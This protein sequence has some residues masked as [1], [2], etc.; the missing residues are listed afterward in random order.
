MAHADSMLDQCTDFDQAIARMCYGDYANKDSFVADTMRPNLARFEALLGDEAF[1]VGKTV[2]VV[3]LKLYEIL[4]KCAI[5][6]PGCLGEESA[7]P[8]L[9][10]FHA[11]VAALPPIAAYLASDR[12]IQR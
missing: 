5:V 2:S 12:C 1:F 9:S 7:F 10:A 4:D 3:D 8:R 11:R 6:E